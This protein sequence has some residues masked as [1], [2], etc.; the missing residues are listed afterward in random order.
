MKLI[1]LACGD[2]IRLIILQILQIISLVGMCF[3][4]ICI[5]VLKPCFIVFV[6]L[7]L[8]VCLK[9]LFHYGFH[10]VYTEDVPKWG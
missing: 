6:P 2:E 9:T 1:T 5:S 4:H 8:H 3:I 7:Y 10:F